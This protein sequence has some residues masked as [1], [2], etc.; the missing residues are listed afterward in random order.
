MDVLTHS[1]V[2]ADSGDEPD[3]PSLIESARTG[4]TTSL[5]ALLS[6][7]HR[8]VHQWASRFTDDADAADDVT[9]EV[10]IKL[11]RQLSSYRGTSRFSTWLFSVTR[12]VALS[13][14]RKERRRAEL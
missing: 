8:R 9:Q 6:R 12:N 13:H 3:L 10:L 5:D 4:R 2:I 7:V 14:R 11:G 1:P